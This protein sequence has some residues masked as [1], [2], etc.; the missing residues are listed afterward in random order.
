MNFAF[1]QWF[2]Q[3]V[4]WLD[5][6]LNLALTPFSDEAFAD[7]TVSARSYRMALRGRLSWRLLRWLIDAVAICFGQTEH[8][9]KAFEN[10]KTRKHLPVAYR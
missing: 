10:E 8:C 7:E 4:L 1:K 2:T 9:M 3:V 5:Q 6:G